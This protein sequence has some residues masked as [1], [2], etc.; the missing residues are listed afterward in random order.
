MM[1]VIIEKEELK[2]AVV[3]YLNKKFEDSSKFECK[4]CINE[5]K[6]KVSILS[7]RGDV[8]ED[9]FISIIIGGDEA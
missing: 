4:L 1:E 2:E 9:Y 5:D 8:V 7:K 3:Q 6:L